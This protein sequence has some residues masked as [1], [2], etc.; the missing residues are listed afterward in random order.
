MLA[1][2]DDPARAFGFNVEVWI[3]EKGAYP[4]GGHLRLYPWV[5]NGEDFLTEYNSTIEPDQVTIKKI[6][7]YS[8]LDFW[9]L[10]MRACGTTDNPKD[11]DACQR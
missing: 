9:Q 4:F 7:A 6:R 10:N 11:N 2:V 1:P 5:N 3:D 8:E